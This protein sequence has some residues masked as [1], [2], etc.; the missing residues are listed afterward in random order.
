MEKTNLTHSDLVEIGYKWCLSRCGF[1]F[2]ELATINHETPDVIGFNS[3]GT[4][5]LEAKTSRS[6]FYAD[7]K[8][9][10]RKNPNEGM[11]D[12]RFFICPKGLIEPEYLPDGWGLIEVNDKGKPCTTFNP[13]GKGNIYSRWEKNAKDERSERAVMYS[14]LRR[15]QTLGLVDRVY[16][17]V[18]KF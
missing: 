2:K 7:K 12:W 9:W 1:A 15:L 8:K 10:F 11:G 3:V 5:L 6:D 18:R 17:T 13:F 4:F 14:A 16:E